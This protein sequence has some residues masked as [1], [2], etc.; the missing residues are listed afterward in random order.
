[1]K[2]RFKTLVFYGLQ[3]MEHIKGLFCFIRLSFI[4]LVK[5]KV[6]KIKINKVSKNLHI[7]TYTLPSYLEKVPITY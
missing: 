4:S 5:R 3:K 6:M 2:W 7:S 1:M